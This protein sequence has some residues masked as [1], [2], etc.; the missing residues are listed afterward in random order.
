MPAGE[1]PM[2]LKAKRLWWQGVELMHG[3][4]AP[5]D[6]RHSGVISAPSSIAFAFTPMRSAIVVASDG[7]RSRVR[8]VAR[9]SVTITGGE[10]CCWLRTSEPTECIEL[11]ADAELRASVADELSVGRNAALDDRWNEPD[12][13][14]LSAATRLRSFVHGAI[15]LSDTERDLLVR[16]IYARAFK[17]WFGGRSR[18]RGD[19]GLDQRR[20]SRVLEFVEAHCGEPMTVERLAKVGAL[21]P[22]HFVRSFKRATGSTPM[23]FVRIRRLERIRNLHRAGRPIAEVAGLMG[24]DR[25]DRF[26]AEFR[27]HFGHACG[28]DP[29]VGLS[30]NS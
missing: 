29:Y 6:G 7:R 8:H 18:Q 14:I 30:L 4:F 13:Y 26:Q 28:I 27:R 23:K 10:P 25:F 24:Y 1:H 5:L 11:V 2:D 21:S 16:L 9:E 22:F 20:L 15:I 3:Y 12:T 17:R 19:G